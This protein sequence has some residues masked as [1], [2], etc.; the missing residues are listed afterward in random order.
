MIK[1]VTTPGTPTV[2]MLA[3]IVPYRTVRVVETR[4]PPPFSVRVSTSALFCTSAGLDE[5]TART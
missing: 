2:L 5:S 1:A 3:W 4:V